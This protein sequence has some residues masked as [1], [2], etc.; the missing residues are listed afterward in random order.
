ML[1]GL[2][3]NQWN[4]V[5]IPVSSLNLGGKSVFQVGFGTFGAEGDFYI[6][7]VYFYNNAAADR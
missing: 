4:Q 3:A 6:D 1:T 5:E 2:V 7:N